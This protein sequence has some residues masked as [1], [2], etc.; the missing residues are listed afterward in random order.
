MVPV[1]SFPG[2]LKLVMFLRGPKALQ[3]RSAIVKL[4]QRY[5]AGDLSLIPEIQSNSVSNAPIAQLARASLVDEPAVLLSSED[6]QSKKRQ[7]EQESDMAE[8]V[9]SERKH[10]FDMSAFELYERKQKLELESATHKQKL[11][12]DSVERKQKI[13]FE[14][15]ERRRKLD[16]Q[17]HEYKQQLTERA[18]TSHLELVEREMTMQL[19]LIENYRGLCTPGQPTDEAGLAVFKRNLLRLSSGPASAIIPPSELLNPTR[20][21][22]LFRARTDIGGLSLLEL[23]NSTRTG[24][25]GAGDTRQSLPQ[26]LSVLQFSLTVPDLKAVEIRAIAFHQHKYDMPPE[27]RYGEKNGNRFYDHVYAHRDHPAIKDI[28]V[29][30]LAE[31]ASPV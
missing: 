25:L 19:K 30:Y 21:D 14:S 22:N 8:L 11:E 9:L 29:K 7:L 16:F 3:H 17:S 6:P 18:K 15:L 12:L 27:K 13:E 31:K 24:S 20:T 1:I 23:V 26:I 10:K 2:I 5:Y 4:M 28:V